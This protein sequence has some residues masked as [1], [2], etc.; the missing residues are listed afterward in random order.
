M[1]KSSDFS[2]LLSFSE[3]YFEYLK[4]N[5]IF[6]L[7][8]QFIL[9]ASIARVKLVEKIDL[10]DNWNKSYDFIVVGAGTAGIVVAVRLA[11][12]PNKTVLLIEAGGERN[13]VSGIPGQLKFENY[14]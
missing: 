6:S 13:V 5:S 9:F 8:F 3:L 4:M 14:K 7:F 11:E 10:K 12:D 1:K 2:S